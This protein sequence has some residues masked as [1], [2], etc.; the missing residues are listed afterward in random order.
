V[1]VVEDGCR[2]IDVGGSVAATRASFTALGI[3][4][5]AMREYASG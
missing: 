3:A 1:F 2:G 4:C 5:L